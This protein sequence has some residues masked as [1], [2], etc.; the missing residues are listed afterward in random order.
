MAPNISY[1]RLELLGLMPAKCRIPFS[2][3]Q[4]L[5]DLEICGV[6]PTHR[7]TRG[8]KNKTLDHHYEVEINSCISPAHNNSGSME[9]SSIG[10][11]TKTFN[12]SLWNSQSVGNKTTELCEYVT[13]RDIDVLCLTET[14]M[15][16]DDQVVIGEISPPGY[17]F[18]SVPRKCVNPKYQRGGVGILYKSQI[19]LGQVTNLDLPNF[20]TYEFTIV[21][22][23]SH[24][25]YIVLI[26][27]PPPSTVNKLTVPKFLEEIEILIDRVNLLPGKL[28]LL[29]DFNVHYDIPEKSDFKRFSTI[30]D[31]VGMVQHVTEPTHR[32]NHILDLVITRQEDAIVN[33]AIEL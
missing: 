4:T 13:N 3:F 6:Q 27:R 10:V 1:S 2:T 25:L 11:S 17:A 33:S 22:N 32:S 15:H 29:G 8:G 26:Y 28:I 20:E 9:N 18:I 5:K 19:N 16:H 30:L 31:S 12:L 24:S 21:S 7:G 14:W 23:I